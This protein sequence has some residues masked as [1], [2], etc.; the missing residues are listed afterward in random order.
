[1]H[2]I[3]FCNFLSKDWLVSTG[4]LPFYKGNGRRGIPGGD[5]VR[6]RKLEE[7]REGKL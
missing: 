5:K 3:F 2:L 7:R 6:G 4:T 1:M